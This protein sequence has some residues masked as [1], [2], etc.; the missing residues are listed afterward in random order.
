MICASCGAENE[1]GNILCDTCGER[2]TSAVETA[3][4]NGPARFMLVPVDG[5]PSIDLAERSVVGRM[6]SC[7]VAVPDKSVSREHARLSRLEGGYLL[8]DLQS[9][10]GTLVNGYRITEATVVRPGDL[11]TFGTVEF[12]MEGP[13]D[14]AGSIGDDM[15]ADGLN[16]GAAVPVQPVD[17]GGTVPEPQLTWPAE[18]LTDAEPEV[19]QPSDSGLGELEGSETGRLADEVVA[20]AA[21]LSDLAQ[22]L[23]DASA[24][25]QS[26]GVP[27]SAPPKNTDA[28]R[29]ILASVPAS[30]MTAEEIEEARVILEG[31]AANPKDFDLLMRVREMAPQLYRVVQQYAQLEQ[32]LTAV[33]EV[34]NRESAG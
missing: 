1:T 18:T 23:A 21:H 30:P 25:A 3:S 12:R 26:A 2:L 20:T 8:E 34:I 31:L 9:T 27:T 32:I 16:E 15:A 11:L 6:N 29:G 28:I 24:S 7:D 22:R 5:G 4:E 10:N 13:G 33:E 19:S 17:A 14:E